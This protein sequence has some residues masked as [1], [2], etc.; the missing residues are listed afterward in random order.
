MSQFPTRE[1][2]IKCNMASVHIPL[3]LD[4][5]LTSNFQSKP[6]IDGSFLTK[7]DDYHK[8]LID[9]GSNNKNNVLFLDWKQDPILS[10]R[11]LGDAVSVISKEGVWDL[12][13]RGRSYAIL[14]EKRGDFD[15]LLI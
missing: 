12:F 9:G 5:K 13:E 15:S 7:P 1:E 3:F 8:L 2:L 14:M 10:D 4:G 6:Y 11:T